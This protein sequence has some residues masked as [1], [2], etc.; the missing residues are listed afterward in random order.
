MNK[1]ERMQL[2]VDYEDA[3]ELYKLT[4]EEGEGK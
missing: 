3:T 1:E 2:E 4:Q